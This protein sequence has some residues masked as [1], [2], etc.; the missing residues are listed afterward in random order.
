MSQNTHSPEY[1]VPEKVWTGWGESMRKCGEGKG[2]AGEGHSGCG[3][4]PHQ[5]ILVVS[6]PPLQL[7]KGEPV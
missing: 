7:G 6:S 1:E 5:R 3:H 4:G 2:R